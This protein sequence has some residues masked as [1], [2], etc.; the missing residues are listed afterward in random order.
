MDYQLTIPAIVRR[1]A[2]LFG[3]KR[4]VSRLA[5][6][7]L[8]RRTYTDILERSTRLAVALSDLGVRPGDRIATLAWSGHQHLEAYLAIPMMGAVLHTLNLRLFPNDLIHIV[9]DAADRVVIVDE[10]L[11]PLFEKI[12]P[13]VSVEHVIVTSASGVHRDQNGGL[14]YEALVAAADPSRFVEPVIAEQDACAMCYTSGTTG[15]PKG[16]LYS[17]RAMVLH[18]M[19][20]GLSRL[21]GADR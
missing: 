17:H 8:D 21:H 15:C 11:L 9:N 13:H 10:C 19:A 18:S 4:V 14:D 5:D 1:A 6:R 2:A 7:G 3:H 20:Q 16:V 12:R